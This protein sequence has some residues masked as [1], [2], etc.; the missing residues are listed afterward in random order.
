MI[1]AIRNNSSFISDPII[2]EENLIIDIYDGEYEEVLKN[3]SLIKSNQ[4]QRQAYYK[5]KYLYYAFIYGLMN[6]PELEQSY[7]DSARVL[8]EKKIVE[9][10]KEPG[11]YSSLSIAYA[12]LN[13]DDKAIKTS[14]K[15]IE[16]MP[17]GRDAWKGV[18]LAEDKAHTYVMI[19][20]YSEALEQIKYLL[21][22]PGNLSVRILELDPRW[23][24]LKNLPEFKK[25]L[26]EYTVN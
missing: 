10:P 14:E 24:P 18:Y 26:E 2:A 13:L 17:L 21:L 16:L 7:Y 22:I 1:N 23:A 9:L 19:K 15:A 25:I 6:K 5:P 8:L 11:L 3:L 12:G 20:R 4:F